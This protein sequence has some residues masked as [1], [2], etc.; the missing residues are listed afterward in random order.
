[1]ITFASRYVIKIVI[2]L[3]RFNPRR[4]SHELNFSFAVCR[5]NTANA[6]L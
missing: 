4:V 1:M 3:A 5:K 2:F 6:A